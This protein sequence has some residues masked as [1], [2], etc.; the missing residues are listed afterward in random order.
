MTKTKN[1]TLI[2]GCDPDSEKSGI[3][4][5]YND[6]LVE[7]NCMTLIEIHK[8]FT[9]E[10]GSK[11]AGYDK[12]ELHIENLNGNK[13][14]SFNHN[15]KMSAAVKYKISESV[16]KCKQVQIEIERMAEHFGIKIV[17]HKVSSAW[18]KGEAQTNQFK[19]ATEWKGRS[20]EDTRSAA[21]F[22]FLGCK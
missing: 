4:V 12:I 5:Y 8:Y 3:A 20:N 6:K 9:V 2:I 14:S 10:N 22:G 18:K 17:H 19:L 15:K 13:S 7:L 21:Y 11:K 1:H 16:G